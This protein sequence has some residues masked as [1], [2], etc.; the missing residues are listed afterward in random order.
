MDSAVCAHVWNLCYC[1]DY[2]K[3]KQISH[4]I[5]RSQA[6][7]HDVDFIATDYYYAVK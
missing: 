2:E 1:D 4:E 6:S 7:K 3:G 5:I